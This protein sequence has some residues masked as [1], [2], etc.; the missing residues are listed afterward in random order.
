MN[1]CYIN[2]LE[3]VGSSDFLN[4]NLFGKP[5]IYYPILASLN[6]GVFDKIMC[7]CCEGGNKRLI[8]KLFP[9]VEI[10]SERDLV[11]EQDKV[12][13]IDASAVMLT[14]ATI[15]DVFQTAENVIQS[16]T[17]KTLPKFDAEGFVC[18]I[19][20]SFTSTFVC[21]SG[22]PYGKRQ[23]FREING[24]CLSETEALT[25]KS[26]N[27]FELALVLKNKE[28]KSEIL[29]GAILHQIEEKDSIMKSGDKQS[30]CLVGHSQLDKWEI[31]CIDEYKV[32]N[33]GISGISSKEYYD[34]ILKD[35]KLKCDSDIYVVMHG[36]ND[37]V[38][39]FTDAEI[40][41]NISRTFEY[42]K[43]HNSDARIFFVKC[44]H[45]NGRL[46]RNNRTIDKINHLFED[47][48]KDIVVLVDVSEF[49]DEFGDLRSEYTIDGLHLSLAGYD[50]L[51]KIIIRAIHEYRPK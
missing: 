48:F 30:I 28:K 19:C 22:N 38:Y 1:I 34:Y 15:A 29:K 42:I 23:G 17:K 9:K 8:K 7:L 31:E 35:E 4:L 43:K 11:E 24:V 3:E 47:S 39:D 20:D 16:C 50:L 41:E 5:V 32:I 14:S 45:T 18:H 26:A 13:E 40:V 49:D 25:I 36:T 37:I 21:Y 51:K 12:M 33:C 10:L 27:D 44:L 2:A 6:A 46:D